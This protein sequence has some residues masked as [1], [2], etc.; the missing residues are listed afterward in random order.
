MSI[1]FEKILSHAAILMIRA[2][3]VLPYK[4]R[5]ALGGALMTYLI[6]PLAG[7]NKRIK[8]NLRYIYPDISDPEIKRIARDVANNFGRTL[9]ELCSADDFKAVVAN[10]E[11]TG[12][13][14]DAIQT[15]KSNGQAIILVSGHF[16]N[17]DAVRSFL[18]QKEYSVGGLYRP[19]KYEDV[20][21]FYL[22]RI[23]QLGEPLFER[24]RAGMAQMIKHL[25]GAN[26]VALLIDQHIRTGVPMDFLGKPAYTAL[27]SA[28]LALKYNALLV[29]C[30]GVRQDDGR[31]FELVFEKPISHTT[32]EQMTQQLNNSLASMIERHAGQWFWVHRRWKPMAKAT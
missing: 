23:K 8:A 30:Y 6:A 28:E 9:V 2:F 13:G 12:P 16:G 22:S 11:I 21:D 3:G 4:R 10:A 18:Q 31:S 32:A 19:M 24:S 27:S 29:P 15:A 5:V 25:K 14:Y 17:Y 7:Y 1:N 26:T 20:N